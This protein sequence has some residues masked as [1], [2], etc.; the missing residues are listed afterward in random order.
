MIVA[1]IHQLLSDAL[2]FAVE[3]IHG[4]VVALVKKALPGIFQLQNSCDGIVLNVV[5]QIIY[6]IRCTGFQDEHNVKPAFLHLGLDIH[7]RIHISHVVKG[8]RKV[9]PGLPG[10]QRIEDDG[11][12]ANILERAVYP[13]GGV[14]A[15]QGVHSQRH[16][17]NREPF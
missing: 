7:L 3:Q 10:L 8:L 4:D 17:E 1:G 6:I 12:L 16:L 5:G 13:F 14:F 2:S 11:C 15:G 9:V